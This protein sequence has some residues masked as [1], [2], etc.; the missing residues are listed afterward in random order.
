[1][2]APSL[3]HLLVGAVFLLRSF[4][5]LV[6]LVASGI[7]IILQWVLHRECNRKEFFLIIELIEIFDFLKFKS[8]DFLPILILEGRQRK[9][10]KFAHK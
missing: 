6:F 5:L 2:P 7:L 8:K 9:T 4:D 3:A 10:F 1:M